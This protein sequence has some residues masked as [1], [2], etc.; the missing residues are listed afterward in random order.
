MW[1]ELALNENGRGDLADKLISPRPWSRPERTGLRPGHGFFIVPQTHGAMTMIRFSI[2]LGLALAAL[3]LLAAGTP[4][5]A[6]NALQRLRS[7]G[8]D[9][10]G[11]SGGYLWC[12]R[13]GHTSG[14]SQLLWG[15]GPAGQLSD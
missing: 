5:P 1:F 12:E 10:D 3:T 14:R 2:P 15:L 11:Y 7:R 9:Y 6:K 8:L 4:A 13:S